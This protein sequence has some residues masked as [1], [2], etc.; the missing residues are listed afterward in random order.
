MGGVECRQLPPGSRCSTRRNPRSN[1][2]R[3]FG[4]ICSSRSDTFA[5]VLSE[6]AEKFETCAC[7]AEVHPAATTELT[8]R[9]TCLNLRIL[10]VSVFSFMY[11]PALPCTPERHSCH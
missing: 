11:A 2:S 10:V 4:G 8:S 6:D 3:A 5:S 1:S 9:I 7:V